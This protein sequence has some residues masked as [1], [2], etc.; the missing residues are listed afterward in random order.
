LVAVGEQVTFDGSGSS[1]PDFDTLTETWDAGGGTVVGDV[2]T[3]GSVPGIYDVEL[4]VNDGTVDSDPDMTTVVVYDPAGG[5]VTGG[6]WIDSPAGAYKDD[7]SLTGKANF[8]FVSKYK[9]GASTPTGETQFLFSA[10]DLN[11][12]SDSYQW[13]V[14]NQ[15]GTNAQYKGSGTINGAGD[16]R[17]MLWAGDGAPD[18]TFR[19]RIWYEDGVE[20]DVYD[21]GFDQVIDG[22][23]IV[24]HTGGKN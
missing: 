22:G 19:I 4:V 15:D 2:Y 20:V 11:F 14:V 8:G 21:N 5:F 12:H 1:D 13:L 9:K 10:G 18:D 17:F 16:Y 3:A 7:I 6:G 23:S 24:I